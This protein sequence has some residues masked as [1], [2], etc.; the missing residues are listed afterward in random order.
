MA[1]Y[2]YSRRAG[3]IT[4][5]DVLKGGAAIAALA[6]AGPAYLRT[7]RANEGPI[8]IGFPVPL[9]G[10]YSTEANDQV[11]CAQLAI[12]RFN[13]AGGLNGR[14]AE[15]VVRDDKLDPGE[16][17]TRALE[18]IESDRVNFLCGSLSASVQLSVNQVASQRGAIYNSIS[19]SDTINEASDFTKYTFHEALNPHLTAGAV[20]RLVFSKFGKKV[21][22]LIADYA[23]GYEMARGFRR[24]G[25][26]FGVQEVA[27][28]KHPL[29]ATDYSTFFPR[30]QAARPEILVCINFGRDQLN[31]IKQANDFG[32]KRQMKIV[33]PVLLVTQRL[34]GGPAAFEGVIGGANYYWGLEERFASARRLNAAYRTKY[35]DAVPS[36]YGALGYAGVYGLLEGVKKA[37]STDTDAVIAA[38]EQM[39]YDAYKGEQYFRK[40]DHQA[41]QSVLIL[42]SKPGSQ[43]KGKWDIFDVVEIQDADETKLRTCEELGHKA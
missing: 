2:R 29:G 33:Y 41:V 1:I 4:R 14:K 23:Y 32:L 19:Q 20:G 28:V 13:E 16:A 12:D 22:Y 5:R 21:A 15:L 6:A 17:A 35:G 38:M 37:G 30:L 42:Q 31:T 8:K 36:D 24:A 39:K 34:A 27:E 26:E 25:K 10:P 11:R 7:A 40:C 18:L 9:S 43:V 3:R